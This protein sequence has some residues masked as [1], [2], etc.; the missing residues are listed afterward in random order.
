MH[1]IYLSGQIW[2]FIFFSDVWSRKLKFDCFEDI[3]YRYFVCQTHQSDNEDEEECVII[4]RWETNIKPRVFSL[5][6]R[7]F[8]ICVDAL[9]PFNN[10]SV[11][12]GHFLG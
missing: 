11:M 2:K 5:K 9:R 6:S 8:F 3:Q 4:K 12:L 1:T 10:F 7:F